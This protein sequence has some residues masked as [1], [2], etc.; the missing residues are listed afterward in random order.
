MM[1]LKKIIF[2]LFNF[3]VIS[4]FLFSTKLIVGQDKVV[5]VNNRVITIKELEKEF[6]QRSKLP[7]LDG[8]QVTKAS[9]LE[10]MIDEDLLKNDVKAKSI[11]LDENQVNQMLEQYK[12][13]YAQEM[14]KTNPNFEF[15]EE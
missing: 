14:A 6:E 11:V 4:S 1:N 13:M 8:S 10:S 3:T 5:K 2:I 7:S 15:N 9:V 12:M